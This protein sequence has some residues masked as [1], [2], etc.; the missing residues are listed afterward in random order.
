MAFLFFLT[1]LESYNT[2]AGEDADYPSFLAGPF[3]TLEKPVI[4]PAVG[5]SRIVG[6]VG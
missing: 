6:C 2:P 3:G 5:D 1:F 4:V